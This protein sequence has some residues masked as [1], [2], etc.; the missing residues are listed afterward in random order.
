AS[1]KKI[2]LSDSP[3]R[4]QYAK[5][6]EDL[7]NLLKEKELS[8]FF[9]YTRL[10]ADIKMPIY[11]DNFCHVNQKGEEILIEKIFEVIFSG[12]QN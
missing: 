8:N 11:T 10:Y 7:S 12:P 6:M 9:D 1:E 4:K 3:S 5:R 2:A